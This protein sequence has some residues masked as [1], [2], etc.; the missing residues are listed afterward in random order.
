[1]GGRIYSTG[2]KND[3]MVF[4]RKLLPA[5]AALGIGRKI[6][7]DGIYGAKPAYAYQERLQFPKRS[8]ISRIELALGMKTSM[9]C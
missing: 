2:E 1:V 9:V 6:I 8:S 4:R 3:L 7:A 5:I